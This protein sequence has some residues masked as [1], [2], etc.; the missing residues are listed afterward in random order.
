MFQK[1]LKKKRT[2]KFKK[3]E[4]KKSLNGEGET[5]QHQHYHQQY[6]H[7]PWQQ[8]EVT[9]DSLKVPKIGSMDKTIQW[10]HTHTSTTCIG[11]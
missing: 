2:K 1:K 4:G 11:K 8:T 5:T 7:Q 6:Q 10:S 9:N 3:N